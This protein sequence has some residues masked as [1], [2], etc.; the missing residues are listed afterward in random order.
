MVDI[1]KNTLQDLVNIISTNEE[2]HINSLNA[3]FSLLKKHNLEKRFYSFVESTCIGSIEL[4]TLL[5]SIIYKYTKD[6]KSLVEVLNLLLKND[7][8]L[9]FGIDII[10]QINRN[11]FLNYNVNPNDIYIL[12]RKVNEKLVLN[13]KEKIN[14]KLSYREIA[15]RN[16]DKIVIVSKQF[17]GNNHA[18]TNIIKEIASILQKN[19]GIE[20]LVMVII[21]DTDVD[22][23]EKIWFDPFMW[24]RIEA[25]GDKF[26][27]ERNGETIIVHQ[28]LLNKK[29]IYKIEEIIKDIY[30]INPIFI[31]N[32]GDC[33]IIADALAKWTTVVTMIFADGYPVTESQIILKL[34][35]RDIDENKYIIEYL[36][37]KSQIEYFY[38]LR[39]PI[40]NSSRQY[41]KEDFGFKKDDFLIAIVGNRLDEE[42]CEDFEKL[43]FRILEIKNNIKLVFIG[44]YSQYINVF[45]E[46]DITKR[47]VFLPYQEDLLAVMNIMDIYL[48][49]IRKGGGISATYALFQGVPVL[50]LRNGDVAL[51]VDNNEICDDLNEMYNEVKELLES[52]EK[53]HK[54]SEKVRIRQEDINNSLVYETRKLV[55][56]VKQMIKKYN[57]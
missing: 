2:E 12:R 33:N 22:D 49:P 54:W 25:Y 35:A 15:S 28:H 4:N 32:M 3:N 11:I 24:N 50:T 19:L 26:Y 27:F 39:M 20:V 6:E 42:I 53:Y 9:M 52:K 7:I 57:I 45:N 21:E 23:L 38:N 36:D 34:S 30:N 48:N 18:P 51:Y 31:L 56:R 17:L 29:N 43:L 16:K 47:T 13:L 8:D 44:E 5:L 1:I 55:H 40:R 46:Q 14:L 37:Y 10:T 41:S